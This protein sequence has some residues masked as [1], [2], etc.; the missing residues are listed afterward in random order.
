MAK[1]YQLIIAI[2]NTGFSDLVMNAARDNGAH[3]GTVAHAR[4]TGTKEIERK[5]GIT[6]S[7]G[8]EMIMILVKSEAAER[9]LKA[10]NDAAG[11][12]SPGKGI[13]FTL[14]VESVAGLDESKLIDPIKP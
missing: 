1:D 6:I 7:E 3:G 11:L 12:Q 2:V 4:G 14:P 10:I 5:Y 13:A 9:V 8:K